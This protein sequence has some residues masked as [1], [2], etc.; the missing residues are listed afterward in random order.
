MAFTARSFF[1]RLATALAI[2][3]LFA[4]LSR[5]GGPKYVT[6]SS[7]FTPPTMGQPVTWPLGQVTYY[8]DQGDLSPILPNTSADAFVANAFS[9]WTSVSTAALTA[10]NAGALAEDVTGGNLAVDGNGT[11]TAPIVITFSATQ[12][13]LGLAYDSYGSVAAH[14]LG[15]GTCDH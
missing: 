14:L 6:G 2:I 3:I 15:A 12:S 7:F 10:I 8:T 5:A 4:A 11:V 13:P 9:Q 1:F